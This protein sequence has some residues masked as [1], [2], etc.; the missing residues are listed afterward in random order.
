MPNLYSQPGYSTCEFR[1]LQLIVFAVFGN[2]DKP[3]ASCMLV[4]FL[5]M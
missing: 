4:Y 2:V 3:P 1:A 5:D